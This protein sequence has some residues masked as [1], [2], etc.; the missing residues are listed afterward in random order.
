MPKTCG[1]TMSESPEMALFAAIVVSRTSIGRYGEVRAR[2]AETAEEA[3]SLE[4]RNSWAGKFGG[5][6]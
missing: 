4:L 6:I 1:C 3:G 5:V 2:R